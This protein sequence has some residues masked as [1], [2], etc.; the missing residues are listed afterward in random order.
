MQ[1]FG[2]E[3]ITVSGDNG[4]TG[5]IAFT[6]TAL[7]QLVFATPDDEVVSGVGTC[8]NQVTL[9]FIQAGT[10]PPLVTST[11]AFSFNLLTTGSVRAG[12]G[13]CST[14]VVTVPATASSVVVSF[15]FTN[16]ASCGTTGTVAV[17]AL[18]QNGLLA[19]GGVTVYFDGL[20]FQVNCMYGASPDLCCPGTTCT[21]ATADCE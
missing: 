17:P 7:A 3:T 15:E 2:A 21:Q 4:A 16:T 1:E 9:N 13:G 8:S 19:D 5:I 20:G 6:S 14:G 18:P 12:Q 10:P 11:S